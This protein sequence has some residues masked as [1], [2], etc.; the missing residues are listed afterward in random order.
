[1]V[2]K[3]SVFRPISKTH[4]MNKILSFLICLLLTVNCFAQIKGTVTDEEGK[5]VSSAIIYINNTYKNT[6]SNEKGNYVLDL[7]KEG[8]FTLVFKHLGYKTQKKIIPIT[9]FPFI[10]DITLEKEE[11][12]LSEIVIN[13][14]ENPANKIIRN[15][16]AYKKDN[17]EKTARFSADF[18]SKGIMKV[19]DLPK[20]ILGKKIDVPDGMVDSTGSGIIYLSET[21]SKIKFEK[22]NRLKETII[23]S[24]VSGKSNGFSYNTAEETPFDFY[25]NNVNLGINLISPL[26]NNAFNYYKFKV[27]STF[28]D[29]NS[30]MINK[31]KVTPKRDS[32]PVFDGYIYIV[33]DSWAIYAV[34][35]NTKGYRMQEEIVNGLNLKQNFSYNS[36]NQ[37]WAKNQQSMD[38]DFSIFG[39]KVLGKFDYVYSN[40]EFVDNFAKKTFTKEI[41]SFEKDSNKK[42]NDFWNAS[43]PIPLTSEETQDYTKKDSIRAIKTSKTYLD[44]IDKKQNKFK[45]TKIFTGY[46]YKNSYKKHRFTYDGLLNLSSLNFNT[47]QGWN[48]DSGFSY[49]HSNPEKGTSTSVKMIANYGFSDHRMRFNGNFSHTFNKQNYASIHFSGGTAAVQFNPNDPI[50]KPINTISSLFFEDN[51][52]KL[53]N[54]EFANAGYGQYVA[55]GSI[56]LLGNIGYEQRKPLFNSTNQVWIKHDDNYFSNNPQLPNDFVTP[57]FNPHHLT[58]ASVFAKINFGNKYISRPDRKIY[59][60]EDKYPVIRVNY[61]NAFAASEKNLNHQFFSANVSYSTILGNKGEFATDFGSGKFINGKGITFADYKH[62][63]GNQT[64]IGTTEKYLNVFNNLPYYTHSTNDSYFEFHSEYDDKGYIMNKIPLLDLL[65]SSLVLGYHNLSVPNTKPY[66]ELTF[67]LNNLGFGKFKM[68]R[69]DYVRSY[70]NGFK[71]DAVVFGLKFFGAVD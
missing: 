41:A 7:K 20:R 21:I 64:H 31:I 16:I 3:Q 69:I 58:K 12:T 24:K 63:N 48:L 45:F 25:D 44:S 37:T 68:F 61:Y 38:F 34:D 36:A 4:K 70:Q 51:Y 19:K 33:E 1:M 26:S 57:A 60:S 53:Y 10:L 5:P 67:G 65:R 6:T 29:E 32:E 59:F 54:K 55:N 40:Y 11:L 8:K 49:N 52:M 50:S 56:S 30:Q 71:G 17:S 39:I 2:T 14:K 28:F 46:T 27:E 22:P 15:A 66:S 18:Y 35:L 42:D 43:R 47:V 9:D 13:P 62:F 23:A